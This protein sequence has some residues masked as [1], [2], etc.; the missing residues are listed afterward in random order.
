MSTDMDLYDEGDIYAS[1]SYVNFWVNTPL[2]V[3]GTIPILGIIKPNTFKANNRPFTSRAPNTSELGLDSA[4]SGQDSVTGLS[5][6]SWYS[7]TV[8]ASYNVSK[9]DYDLVIAGTL[10][11]GRQLLE[12]LGLPLDLNFRF[13]YANALDFVE[14]FWDLDETFK[15]IMKNMMTYA[16][17]LWAIQLGYAKAKT[18]YTMTYEGDMS[19]HKTGKL[20]IDIVLYDMCDS[21]KETK[22]VVITPREGFSARR[23]GITDSL[24]KDA[25]FVF[26]AP[27]PL[28]L[29][30]VPIRGQLGRER[31]RYD[32]QKPTMINVAV[33]GHTWCYIYHPNTDTLESFDAGGAAPFTHLIVQYI[34]AYYK[35]PGMKFENFSIRAQAAFSRE[36]PDLWCQ[37][38]TF[39]WAYQRMFCDPRKLRK[40]IYDHL[41]KL[42]DKIAIQKQLYM[43]SRIAFSGHQPTLKKYMLTV[44]PYL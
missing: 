18:T 43:F 30:A 13:C 25:D 44:K 42:E 14:E 6:F 24:M 28:V 23:L 32:P 10:D 34:K 37:T 1:P 33:F 27:D 40:Y 36:V 16:L 8:D 11:H 31:E 19:R 15:T 4:R 26:C 21:L 5:F 20:T 39:W 38:W 12:Q 9:T 41:Q 35:S 2:K 3:F 29:I 7:K 17:A 22:Q